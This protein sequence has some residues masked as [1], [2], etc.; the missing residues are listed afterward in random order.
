M[1]PK[2]R[3][4]S[5]GIDVFYQV[6]N[7]EVHMRHSILILILVLI[8]GCA[9]PSGQ[10]KKEDFVWSTV[11]VNFTYQEA[12]RRIKEGFRSCAWPTESELYIDTKSGYFDVFL[13]GM[14]KE[15]TAWVAGRIDI[16]ESGSQ[17]ATVNIGVN[18]SY[19]AR[20]SFMLGWTGY[21]DKKYCNENN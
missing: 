10:M 9:T 15:K 21:L 13:P 3:P 7:K 5:S 1:G 2:E 17:T 12:Y 4:Q 6:I 16:T 11:Q 14:F 20:N 8:T 18:N 19:M